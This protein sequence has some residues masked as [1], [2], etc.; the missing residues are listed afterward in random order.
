MNPLMDPQKFMEDPARVLIGIQ[1]LIESS[2][3]MPPLHSSVI[4]MWAMST[5]FDL[6]DSNR[7]V[8]S[9]IE[10]VR[11]DQRKGLLE[12]LA[13]IAKRPV[14]GTSGPN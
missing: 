13:Q 4:A 6:E 12:L 14:P 1:R 8:A 11:P 5:Y 10:A 3:A 2:A 7:Q 9:M